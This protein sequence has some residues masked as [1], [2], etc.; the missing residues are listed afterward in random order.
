MRSFRDLS[1]TVGFMAF[2]FGLAIVCSGCSFE[3]R[4]GWQ[5]KTGLDRTEISPEFVEAVESGKMKRR[6]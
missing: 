5:G 3:V 1:I 4:A 2:L 6:Y